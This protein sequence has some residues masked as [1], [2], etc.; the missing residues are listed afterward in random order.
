MVAKD[1]LRKNKKEVK[2]NDP[3]QIFGKM[4]KRAVSPV[5]ETIVP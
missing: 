5:S 1:L 3:E 4:P 2:T